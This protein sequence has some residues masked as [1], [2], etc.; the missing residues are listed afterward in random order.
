MAVLWEPKSWPWFMITDKMT[1]TSKVGESF[2]P[3]KTQKPR[4]FVS[5]VLGEAEGGCYAFLNS[6]KYEEVSVNSFEMKRKSSYLSSLLKNGLKQIFLLLFLPVTFWLFQICF[7]SYTFSFSWTNQ[8]TNI[9]LAS[10]FSHSP[11]LRIWEECSNIFGFWLKR[12]KL[13]LADRR[14]QSE[15]SSFRLFLT[16]SSSCTHLR[17]EL[18]NPRLK[19]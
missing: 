10:F 2:N 6:I 18:P 17:V 7:V 1:L 11:P 15:V 9:F 4:N 3:R 13:C 19:G 12:R 5:L 16:R 14:A 8:M